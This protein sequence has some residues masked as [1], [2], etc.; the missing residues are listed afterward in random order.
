MTAKNPICKENSQILPYF[1]QNYIYLHPEHEN[2]IADLRYG[3][4]PY[5]DKSLW[6]IKIDVNNPDEHVSFTNL[7][8]FNDSYYNDFWLMLKGRFN[9]Q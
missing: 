5:D 4:F 1:S 7:R 3:T 2:M 9:S 8:N 6:G